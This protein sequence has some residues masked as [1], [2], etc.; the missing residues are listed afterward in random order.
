MYVFERNHGGFGAWGEVVRLVSPQPERCDRFGKN[1]SLDANT[2]VVGADGQGLDTIGYFGAA[3]VFERESDESRSW[4]LTAVLDGP[5]HY[6]T[7]G[8]GIAVS[9]DDD[10]IVIGAPGMDYSNPGDQGCD[11]G[12]VFAFDRNQG[13]AGQWGQV[14]MLTASDAACGAGFGSRVA[15]DED[16]LVIEGDDYFVFERPSDTHDWSEVTKLVPTDYA[17]GAIA[18]SGNTIVVGAET[19]PFNCPPGFPDCEHGGAYVFERHEGGVNN[20]GLAGTIGRSQETYHL[21]FSAD[22]DGDTLALG[23]PFDW[24]IAAS[25]GVVSVFVRDSTASEGWREVQKIT[26]SD[27]V[28]FMEFGTSLEIDGALMAVGALK[29]TTNE[30]GAAYVLSAELFADG[31]ESGD[32]SAW[33]AVVP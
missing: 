27:A 17:G 4:N 6:M 22:V 19:L 28:E 23:T 33:S 3:F 1:V 2:L 11:S 30:Q 29:G 12:A 21:G 9:V 32:S 8:F 16:T 25:A 24:E 13:G 31:F 14:V 7:G 20:W 5:D 10:T 26:A 18:V 15:V